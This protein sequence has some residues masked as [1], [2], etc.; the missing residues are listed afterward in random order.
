MGKSSHRT[1][2]RASICALLTISSLAPQSMAADTAIPPSTIKLHGQVDQID[3]AM[4]AAGI[5]LESNKLP[6]FVGDVRLGSAAHYGGLSRGDKVISAN[7]AAN[8]LR[9]D[10]E[11]SGRLY[12]LNLAT[13]T[14]PETVPVATKK[15]GAAN[16]PVPPK[17]LTEAEKCKRI[18][19]NDII[20]V[21]DTSGSMGQ[22]LVTQPKTKWK[23]CEDFVTS[24]SK[25]VTPLLNGRGIKMVTFNENFKVVPQCN[26]PDVL[27]VFTSTVPGGATNLGAPVQQIFKDYFGNASA[28]PLLVIVLTDGVPSCGPKI[29]EIIVEG[30]KKMKSSDQIQFA[31]LEIGDESDGNELLQ[32]LDYYLCNAGAQYDIVTTVP[33]KALQNHTLVDVLID[34]IDNK[35]AKPSGNLN[36]QMEQLRHEIDM[37]R[38]A[39]ASSNR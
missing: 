18:A 5:T 37:K 14:A 33:F 39:A 21:I 22:Q 7:I 38:R 4:R 25:G 23:W 27:Q 28:H 26:P 12:S 11:R 35:T 6:S 30:T 20:I 31:F 34:A 24:F 36:E 17:P 3:Y 13:T 29:E 16:K 15:T 1:L 10:F 9:V 19:Q 32:Y 8:S 2:Q